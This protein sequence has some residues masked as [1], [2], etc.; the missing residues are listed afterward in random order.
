MAVKGLEIDVIGDNVR[1]SIPAPPPRMPLNKEQRDEMNAQYG[2]QLDVQMPGIFELEIMHG[3][4][5]PHPSLEHAYES[6]C[7]EPWT[8]QLVT[9]LLIASNQRVVLETG[10]FTGQTSAW[11]ACALERLGGGDLTAVDIDPARVAMIAKRLSGLGLTRVT[12]NVV[13]SDILAYLP[14]VPNK[15]IGF[16][17]VDD[18][19]TALHVEQEINLLWDKVRPGGIITFHDVFG[20]CD[21]QKV[22]RKYGGYCIDIPRLGAAGGL[23]ILQIG[24]R[25]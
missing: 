10:G 23:G 22:V 2:G 13:E 20:T 1:F 12:T 11:L 21:L 4:T 16:A 24:N 14:T 3:V 18:N 19:H 9:S 15:S 7:A 8:T 17:F 5:F 25:E 6:G